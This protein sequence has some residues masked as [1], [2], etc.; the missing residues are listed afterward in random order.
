MHQ[1][2]IILKGYACKLPKV[3]TGV[4]HTKTKA[5]AMLS[6]LSVLMYRIFLDSEPPNLFQRCE[7][8][9]SILA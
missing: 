3:M 8:I 6:R 1:F 2:V 7:V 9:H 5:R 4:S